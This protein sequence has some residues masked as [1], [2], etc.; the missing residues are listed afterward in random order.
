MV[1]IFEE[2]RSSFKQTDK[3]HYIFT[4]K[5]LTNWSVAMMRYDFCGLFYNLFFKLSE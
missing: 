2:I 5:D 4:P 1:R 3:A